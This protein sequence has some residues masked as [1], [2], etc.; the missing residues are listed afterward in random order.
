MTT[1]ISLLVILLLEIIAFWR[2]DRMMYFLAGFALIIAGFNYF[3][4][5]AGISVIVVIAGIYN[6]ARAMW[7]T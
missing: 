5:S 7:A 1:V 2:N 6:F 3:S 4:V